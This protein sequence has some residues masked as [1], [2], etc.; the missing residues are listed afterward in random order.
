MERMKNIERVAGTILENASR[1]IAR[2]RMGVQYFSRGNQTHYWAFT[3][4]RI[5]RLDERMAFNFESE[6]VELRS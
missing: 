5:K 6:L 1:G 3:L 4:Q 2:D